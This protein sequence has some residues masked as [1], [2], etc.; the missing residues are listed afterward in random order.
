MGKQIVSQQDAGL[1]VPASIDCREMP[2]HLGFIQHVVMDERRGVNHLDYGRQDVVGGPNAAGCLGRQAAAGP[3]GVVCRPAFRRT[4]AVRRR[5]VNRCAVPAPAPP[6]LVPD[7][8]GS[9]ANRAR[10]AVGKIG[11]V[12]DGWRV[13]SRVR[14]PFPAILRR[15]RS[16]LRPP[17]HCRPGTDLGVGVDSGV[18]QSP[19]RWK[20]TAGPARL[21]LELNL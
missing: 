4:A 8:A 1:V 10:T 20:W 14:R 16:K 11:L 12:S 2:P 9:G 15:R 17:S 5:R 3:D 21:F 13:D 6:R 18:S 7:R 19:R